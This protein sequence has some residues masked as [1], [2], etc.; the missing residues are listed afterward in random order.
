MDA[1]SGS[2]FENQLD[3]Y[4]T[5]LG[6]VKAEQAI[7]WAKKIAE[8][9]NPLDALREAVAQIG[10]PLGLDFLR[11]GIMHYAGVASAQIGKKLAGLD[12]RF[13]EIFKDRLDD[14][15]R[16]KKMS[17][18]DRKKWIADEVQRRKQ[19]RLAQAKGKAD[20][21]RTQAGDIASRTAGKARSALGGDND[22]GGERRPAQPANDGAGEVDEANQESAQGK[23]AREESAL[24]GASANPAREPDRQAQPVDTSDVDDKGV[25][26]RASRLASLSPD[27]AV[28][29]H[30]R[31]TGIVNEKAGQLSRVRKNAMNKASP[32]FALPDSPEDLARDIQVKN[33]IVND[34]LARQNKKRSRV[35]QYDEEGNPVTIRGR[36]L[37]QAQPRTAGEAQL[38]AQQEATNRQPALTE[39]T[40]VDAFTGQPIQRQ[41]NPAPKDDEPEDEPDVPEH[42]ETLGGA[43]PPVDTRARVPLAP[44]PESIVSGDRYQ[45]P[46]DQATA[47]PFSFKQASEQASRANLARI[48][49]DVELPA[50]DLTGASARKPAPNNPRAVNPTI[51]DPA[52]ASLPSFKEL[53]IDTP[54]VSVADRA[55]ALSEQL[56]PSRTVPQTAVR[57]GL[58]DV[59]ALGLP[60]APKAGVRPNR[61]EALASTPEV[62]PESVREAPFISA[63]TGAR[64]GT[65]L[66]RATAVA[67]VLAPLA[68][69]GTAQQ[70]ASAVG[71]GAG[72][73]AGTEAITRG[74][75]ALGASEGLV[76]GAGLLPSAIATLAGQGT[77]GQKAQA[78]GEQGAQVAGQKV[79]AKVVNKV[80]AP[81]PKPSGAGAEGAE[82]AEA[83]AEAGEGLEGLE[84]GLLASGGETGGLGFLAAGLVGIGSALASIFAPHKK[85]PPAP[86]AVLPNLS[87]PV[88][89]QGLS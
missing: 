20:E 2:F 66:G 49:P 15:V 84:A 40:E 70:K 8:A 3:S 87:I 29:E 38:D 54:Q 53:G 39:P 35:T 19:E 64:L 55:R 12:P 63:E 62:S 44:A 34:A 83:G 88:A 31:L 68:G 11:E 1:R 79:V 77:A 32:E 43:R 30:G 13:K 14:L 28:V 10:T 33:K 25:S 27:D 47:N 75:Q 65:N 50:V 42:V 78:L 16:L 21:L 60:R 23:S 48:L 26:E 61:P 18:E 52:L 37:A 67:G 58:G 46:R 56:V 4:R 80:T 7:S 76:E 74:A 57:G 24:D 6:N 72:V 51:E 9:E 41:A 69:Q 71:E 86:P 22:D 45:S 73:L 59:P 17:P 85:A 89:Q 5:R 82:G 36:R 81:E